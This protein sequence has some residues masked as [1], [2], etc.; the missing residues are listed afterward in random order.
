[1]SQPEFLTTAELAALLRI[2]ERKVYD[3]AATGAVPCTKAMGKLLFPR[4]AIDH[5]LEQ[6]GAGLRLVGRQERKSVVV[7]SHDP[8]LD[9]AL[10]ESRCSLATFL[11]GSF[12][13]LDRFGAG[14]AV[15]TGLHVHEGGNA[16]NVATVSG[17]F[18]QERVVLV[19][20]AWRE[21][22][23]V[24]APNSAITSLADL[25]G[26]RVMARQAEA[27]SQK[28]FIALLQEQG[29]GIGDM[30]LS[31]PARNETDAALGVLEGKADA[32]FG[33][34][35]LARQHRLAFIPVIRE[36]FDLLVDRR[37]YFEPAL[38]KLWTFCRSRQFAEKAAEQAGYDVSG[39]GRVHF[40]GA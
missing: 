15:A 5:W 40:N 8:L 38:Q 30:N 1:M 22:G 2:K 24:V 21:R 9:W 26:R 11:D 12:D 34:A 20:F 37:A 3:L 6:S 19:E 36:R 16:W 39:L 33:L 25:R 18:S 10:R 29:I 32:A 7:G 14:E 23:L 13:G 28:L 35:A 31:A 17:R 4:K 27:G